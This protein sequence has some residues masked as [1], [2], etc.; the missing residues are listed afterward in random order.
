SLDSR[1]VL[2]ASGDGVVRTWGTKLGRQLGAPMKHD[3]VRAATFSPDGRWVLTAG[4]DGVVRMW[5]VPHP[6]PARDAYL[7]FESLGGQRVSDDGLV[8]DV[9]LAERVSL[10]GR[11]RALGSGDW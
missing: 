8:I 5:E 1:L 3:G 9:P 10:R 7:A 11:L 4:T 6:E 2:T